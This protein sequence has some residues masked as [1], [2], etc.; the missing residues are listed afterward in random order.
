MA[1]MNTYGRHGRRRD[2]Q[3]PPRQSQNPRSDEIGPFRRTSDYSSR[4]HRQRSRVPYVIVIVVVILA[5]VI[6]GLAL[7]G[8]FSSGDQGK[9]GSGASFEDGVEDTQGAAPVAEGVVMTLGGSQRTYVLVGEEYLEAGC[10]A[11]DPQEGDITA[12]VTIEG[13][14]DTS[15][16][17]E[18][19]VRYTAT[20][21]TGAQATADRVVCVVESFEEVAT[22]LP[23]LMYYYVYT[24]DDPPED[25]NNNYLLN[26]KLEAQLSYLAENDYYYPSYEEVRAFVEGTHTLP[27]KSVVLTFDDGEAGFL[28]Y[29]IPL[30]DEYQ[31]P[32]TSFIIC[33]DED[34]TEKILSNA[35]PYVSFQS[36]SFA[37]HQDG[38]NIGHGGRIHAMTQE[39]I[40][41]DLRQAQDILGTT[42]AFAYPFGDNND[43]A[44]A[45]LEQA[46]V[47][48]AFT[49]DNDR[50]YP[51]DNPLLLSRVRIS[52]EYT[53]EG[54]EGLVAPNNA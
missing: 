5:C 23:V 20:N 49:T 8:A 48:C 28:E 18:Y 11:V 15:T 34:A 52:G 3:N 54:F 27:A 41:D 44:V 2:G 39:E 30:L 31:V 22:S 40:F 14:V 9:G 26:T 16:P 6:V 24:E 13:D 36:H 17:G 51:G 46:G 1:D 7:S 4:K 45:A 38:S 47:L 19:D 21:S 43:A 53:Q 33:S 32:A 29:G 35:S 50:V 37:M 10:H 25:L 42:E 12:S